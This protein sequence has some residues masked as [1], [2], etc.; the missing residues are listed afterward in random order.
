MRVRAFLISATTVGAIAVS[1]SACTAIAGAFGG[2][3]SFLGTNSNASCDRRY[4][5]RP[6]PFCQE[7]DDT[8]A[9][10]EFEDD[11]RKKFPGARTSDAYC[12]R[13]RRVGGCVD[14]KHNDDNSTV[15]DWFY[16]VSEMV[17]EAGAE[18]AAIVWNEA[19]VPEFEAGASD[20]AATLKPTFDPLQTHL[21]ADD[22]KAKC[23]DRKRY[24]NGA[25]YVSPP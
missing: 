22:V 8:V 6:E 9:G 17:A 21:T 16:D 18:D 20:G 10:S 3:G 25:H 13:E 1:L 12:P 24:E 14:E 11:C 5:D 15:T 7:I 4:A 19:G 23:A 2:L